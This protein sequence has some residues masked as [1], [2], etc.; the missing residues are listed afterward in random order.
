MHEEK[1]CHAILGYEHG[2]NWG[3]G[4]VLVQYWYWISTWYQ[5]WKNKYRPA[6]KISDPS[7]SIAASAYIGVPQ[8][9]ACRAHMI[10]TTAVCMQRC[11]K[12][13]RFSIKS[14]KNIAAERKTCH[15]QVSPG[16][17]TE[18]E[19]FNMTDLKTP[20]PVHFLSNFTCLF[21]FF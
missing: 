14:E 7:V 15:A 11:G 5:P 19:E 4:G 12:E 21:F 9:P 1:N 3:G 13:S 18:Q 17:G 20:D 2:G 10:T 8:C 6:S 16:G